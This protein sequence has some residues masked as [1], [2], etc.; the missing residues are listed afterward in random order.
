MITTLLL[1]ITLTFICSIFL[2][3]EP[4][5]FRTFQILSKTTGLL[6]DARC[7]MGLELHLK[8]ITPQI[9]YTYGNNIILA[10]AYTVVDNYSIKYIC[11]NNTT[12]RITP[13]Y[14]S[15][16]FKFGSQESTADTGTASVQAG[17]VIEFILYSEY[18]TYFWQ[19]TS[20]AGGTVTFT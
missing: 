15:T 9:L 11:R 4:P 6:Y 2:V 7:D 19:I 10:N 18:N 16:K 1:F 17:T 3:V 12:F 20:L 13:S 8:Q 5:Y 14:I